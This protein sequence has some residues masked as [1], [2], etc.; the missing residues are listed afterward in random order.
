MRRSL[1][2][3]FLA[4]SLP[5]SVPGAHAAPACNPFVPRRVA[6]AALPANVVVHGAYLPIVGDFDCNGRDDIFWYAPGRAHDY[7]WY[8]TANGF[9]THGYTVNGVYRTATADLDGDGCS[10]IVW[11]APGAA[12]DSIW[13][14]RA[15]KRFAVA[16]RQVWGSYTPIAMP[17][18][19]WWFDPAQHYNAIWTFDACCAHDGAIDVAKLRPFIG[20][21]TVRPAV[22]D[23]DAN[24]RSDVVMYRPGQY[25]AAYLFGTGNPRV[26]SPHVGATPGDDLVPLAGNF[27]GAPSPATGPDGIFWYGRGAAPD[28]LWT[29]GAA[30]YH[31]TYPFV[32]RRTTVRGAGYAPVAGD[33]DGDGRDDMLWYVPGTGGRIWTNVPHAL[34]LVPPP[35]PSAITA[36]GEHGC[37]IVTG[38][39]Q[40]WGD[41]RFGEL[42]DGTRV[43]R[44]LPARVR[45]LP[46]G[47][48]RVVAGFGYTCAIAGGGAYCWGLNNYGELGDGT[49]TWRSTP[50][51][52]RGLDRNVTA[53]AV[54]DNYTGREHT[55]AIAGGAY[56]WGYNGDGELGDGTTASRSTPAKVQGLSGVTAVSAGDWSSC[57]VAGG[58]ARCW[59]AN[60]SGQLG[61]GGTTASLTPVPVSGLVQDVSEVGAGSASACAV[62]TTGSVWCWG[63]NTEGEL[64]TGDR[65]SSLVPVAVHGMASGGEELAVGYQVACVS[66]FA[67]VYCWGRTF[68]PAPAHVLGLTGGVGS[69]SANVGKCAITARGDP[70]CWGPN[71]KGELGNG[72]TVRAPTFD[73][74]DNA[75]AI[76]LHLTG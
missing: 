51:P 69:L 49:T 47:A 31:G 72:M 33:F 2:A 67:A 14:G 44:P 62:R 36:G 75:P 55:C 28:Y 7:V 9:V 10:D 12:M 15:T 5:A 59:G 24:G 3:L 76:V 42:G 19:L 66:H 48:T 22:L 39:V 21:G 18:K 32:R 70:V 8:S 45:G 11:H 57:A 61:T 6:P 1:V 40:C 26:F 27:D 30:Y 54:S 64:G 25:R 38:I 34:P 53:I 74:T 46:P 56:C 41:N 58:A 52:V 68:Q 37:A 65:T 16:A 63:A 71:E 60:A 13:F 17:G 43:S 20:A 50:V 4:A 73:T 29:S 35:Y 23:V